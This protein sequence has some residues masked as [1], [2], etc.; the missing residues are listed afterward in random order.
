MNEAA[1]LGTSFSAV[2]LFWLWWAV[3]SLFNVMS[4]IAERNSTHQP[5]DGTDVHD[6][7]LAADSRCR[8]T[9]RQIVPSFDEAHFIRGAQRAYE[10]I[11]QA[12]ASSD[13]DTLHPLLAPDVF[14][15]F[16]DAVTTRAGRRETILLTFI[17]MKDA[18]MVEA[19]ASE[20]GIAI[21]VRFVAEIVRSTHSI[22]GTV[23]EGD[24]R[25]TIETNDLWTFEPDPASA[26][27][28]WLVT[29]TDSA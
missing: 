19:V 4:E 8:E 9:I 14:D 17:G 3:L 26:G 27:R 22:D 16:E 20:R 25:E 10:M 11:L 28:S 13:L 29:A 2:V 6:S 12:F 23:V 5:S 18:R 21:T 24:P 15:A 1:D 7:R